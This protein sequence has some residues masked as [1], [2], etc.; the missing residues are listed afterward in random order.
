MKGV[1]RYSR[2]RLIESL[3]LERIQNAHLLVAGSGAL[4]NEVLKNLALYGTRHV[5]VAD[6]DRVSL[7]NLGRCVLFREE[8]ALERK[9]KAQAA[10]ERASDI[11]RDC[12]VEAITMQIQ[13]LEMSRFD[14]F[15]LVFGCVDSVETRV[16]LNA[17]CYSLKIPYVDG[18]IRGM[19]GRVQTVLPP[20]TPCF[21][22][23]LNG[24]HSDQM[25]RIYSCSGEERAM[26][27]VSIPS[28]I[29]TVSIVA[30]IQTLEA[31]KI[32]SGIGTGNLLLIDG[33]RSDFTN[34]EVAFS[35]SCP[36]HWVVA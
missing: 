36:N 32:L 1:D 11:N 7:S 26:P 13:E 12:S 19:M 4:G 8:D 22:C 15:D 33:A 23:T 30:G 9:Y 2:I 6:Y 3:N 18:G 27:S 35:E 10:A 31:M 17:L 21:A 34:V 28:E 25:D 29:A 24:T 5:S 14:E 16:Y 20:I